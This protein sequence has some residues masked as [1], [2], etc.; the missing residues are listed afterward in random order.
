[1]ATL[2]DRAKAAFS[3]KHPNGPRPTSW[4]VDPG[5][6]VILTGDDG[7]DLAR[8][9]TFGTRLCK[10]DDPGPPGEN[11]AQW[12]ERVECR[13]ERLRKQKPAKRPVE[14]VSTSWHFESMPRPLRPPGRT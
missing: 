7:K 10:Q 3:S 13:I 6:F 1:M 5:G 4:S 8:Y 12:R 9:K 14:E 2:L 11:A